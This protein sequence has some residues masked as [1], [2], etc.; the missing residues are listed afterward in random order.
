MIVLKTNSNYINHRIRFDQLAPMLSHRLMDSLSP[1]LRANDLYLRGSAA[2]AWR[3]SLNTVFVAAL[4]LMYQVLLLGPGCIRIWP[5]SG[6]DFSARMMSV[7]SDIGVDES[8][9]VEMSLFPA[10]IRRTPRGPDQ[11]EFERTTVIHATE[12][13]EDVPHQL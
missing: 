12:L 11:L 7:T 2:I 6:E 3:D 8:R 5:R 13:L 10:I 9:R 1:L 4:K